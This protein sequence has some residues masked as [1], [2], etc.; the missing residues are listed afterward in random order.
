MLTA[1]LRFVQPRG[2]AFWPAVGCGRA[3]LGGRAGA[4][5]VTATTGAGAAA[6]IAAGT[7]AGTADPYHLFIQ[8]LTFFIIIMLIMITRFQSEDQV[9]IIILSS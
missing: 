2:A 9:C 1:L 5:G 4:A 8:P 7:A 3:T 6:G